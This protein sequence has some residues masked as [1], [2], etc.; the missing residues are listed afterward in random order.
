MEQVRKLLE[1]QQLNLEGARAEMTQL[2]ETSQ[3]MQ[4]RFND[5]A[6]VEQ[7]IMGKIEAYK[8]LIEPDDKK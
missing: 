6:L 8:S 2:L 4:A 5:L 1:E 3:K 7:Q